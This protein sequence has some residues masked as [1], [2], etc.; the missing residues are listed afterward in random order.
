MEKRICPTRPVLSRIGERWSMAVCS[1]LARGVTQFGDLRTAL[2]GVS[3]KVLSETLVRLERDGL[4]QREVID[5]RPP[6]VT[7]RLTSLGEG[8]LR[9][10]QPIVIWSAKNAPLINAAQRSYDARSALQADHPAA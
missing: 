10:V 8:L 2:R 6:S 9:A 3:A 1:Q 7:Y 5:G 4:I